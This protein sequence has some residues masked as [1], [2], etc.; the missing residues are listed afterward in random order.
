MGNL[1]QPA[2]E[3]IHLDLAT[4]PKARPN[5]NF[6]KGIVYMPPA[7]EEWRENM[8]AELLTS[9]VPRG[10]TPDGPMFLECRFGRDFTDFQIYKADVDRPT[11]VRGDLDNL[12]GGFMETLQDA[13]I[14]IND[15]QI[16]QAS[17]QLW[18]REK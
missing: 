4:K 9:V 7:Y 12:L 18:T 13:G 2:G 10:P 14:I 16:I 17:T 11:G 1:Q 3:L 15:S 6:S 5:V 8:V